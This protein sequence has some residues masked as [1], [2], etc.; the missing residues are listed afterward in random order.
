LID[1]EKKSDERNLK[2]FMKTGL[3]YDPSIEEGKDELDFL[4]RTVK[5]AP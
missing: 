4:K 5:S 1:W 2:P 3:V